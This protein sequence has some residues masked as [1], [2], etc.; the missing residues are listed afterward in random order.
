MISTGGPGIFFIPNQLAVAAVGMV[1]FSSRL[2]GPL[3]YSS[4][5]HG[6]PSGERGEKEMVLGVEKKDLNSG[7]VTCL[8]QG[9]D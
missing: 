8:G 5:S 2:A 1:P 9:W 4:D 6:V 7:V 3:P